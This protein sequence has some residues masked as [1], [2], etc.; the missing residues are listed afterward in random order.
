VGKPEGSR[1]L[2]RTNRRWEDNISMDLQEMGWVGLDWMVEDR[3]RWRVFVNVVMNL[4][5]P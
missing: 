3:E 5:A 4:R 2:G 1:P